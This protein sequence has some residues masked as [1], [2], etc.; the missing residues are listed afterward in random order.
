MWVDW[1]Y[2]YEV[3]FVMD[4]NFNIVMCM[5]FDCFV[6][7]VFMDSQFESECEV[8][9]NE[10]RYWVDDDFEGMMYEKLYDFVLCGHFYGVFIIGWLE[11]IQVILV[12]DCQLFYCI[13]YVFNNVVIVIVGNVEMSY[14][15]VLFECYYGD[16]E[17]QEI[18]FEVLVVQLIIEKDCWLELSLLIFIDRLLMSWVSLFSTDLE[19]AVL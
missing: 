17:V 19:L 5:E 4:D 18:L 3:L 9:I 14:V 16:I 1:M 13:Y 10:C 12:V 8:V 11:D 15:L 2:Y 6:N 7:L